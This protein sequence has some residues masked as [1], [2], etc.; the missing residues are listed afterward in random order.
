MR[1]FPTYTREEFESGLD[2]EEDRYERGVR[3]RCAKLIDAM[4]DE[5]PYK[6]QPWARVALGIAARAVRRG[7]HLTSREKLQNL[8]ASMEEADRENGTTENAKA[9]AIIRGMADSDQTR[10]R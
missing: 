3:E 1:G 6:D 9:I 8:A 2:A 4:L 10:N 7:R 5:E